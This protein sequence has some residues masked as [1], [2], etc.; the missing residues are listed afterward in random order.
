MKTLDVLQKHPRVTDLLVDYYKKLM[1]DSMSR[2][3][4]FTVEFREFMESMDMG[5]I[6][7]IAVQMIEGNA[8]TVLEFFDEHGVHG[9]LEMEFVDGKPLFH[10]NINGS[11]V[12]S[13]PDVMYD[14]GEV[15]R[16]L[17]CECIAY[18]DNNLS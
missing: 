6:S 2:D 15:S 14:R 5:T 4:E 1:Y 18:L 7:N 17:V 8:G 12:T 3:P 13:D 16:R 9:C 10:M 11:I